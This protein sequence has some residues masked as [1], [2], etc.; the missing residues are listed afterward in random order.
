MTK[1]FA[2]WMAQVNTLLIKKCGMTADDLQDYNYMFCFR[3]GDRP[4][5]VV[6]DV[7]DNA[8]DSV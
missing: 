3:C 8:Q 4:D 6:Q 7:L 2:Q 1:T 5:E